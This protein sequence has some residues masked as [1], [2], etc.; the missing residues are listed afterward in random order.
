MEKMKEYKLSPE[1]LVMVAGSSIGT[2][3]KFYD[4]GYWYKQN[5]LG[6]EGLAEYLASKVLSC[7]N[8]EQYVEY[9]RCKI[10]GQDG[11]RSANFILEGESYISLQRLYDTYQGGQLSEQMRMR[12]TIQDRVKFVV[13]FVFRVTGLDIKEQLRKIATLDMLL[14]NTDRHFNNIGII[15]DVSRGIYKNAPVFDNGNSLLSNYGLFPFDVP[16]EENIEKAIGQ[17]FSA[18]LESQAQALGFGLKV[19]YEQLEKVLSKE[20][21]SRAL[22]TLYKQLNR[23][24]GIIKDN[25][26]YIEQNPIRSSVMDKLK[27]NQEICNRS[28][29]DP[30]GINQHPIDREER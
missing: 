16:I 30:A 25:S 22:E 12:S 11:C 7:S 20:S 9:E 6:Y 1:A 4:R 18:S 15:A 10:N 5:N 24:E 27:E 21:D 19:N 3:R 14:L 17:P 26:V 2:Q 29:T 28:N 13:D 23:Y 8:I